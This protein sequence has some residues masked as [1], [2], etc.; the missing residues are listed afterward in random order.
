VSGFKLAPS[1]FAVARSSFAVAMGTPAG[2]NMKPQFDGTFKEAGA[3]LETYVL[4]H[5]NGS[6]ALVDTKTATCVSWKTADGKEMITKKDTVHMLNGAPL[7]GEFVPEERAKKVS[8]DRMIFKC[9]PESNKELEYRCDVTM[10]E[11]SLEYDITIK[12]SGAGAHDIEN[13]LK[14]NIDPSMKVRLLPHTV[15]A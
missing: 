7:T 15:F 6:K 4:E 11:D 5:E 14:F 8:F 12:N 2:V 9:T 1:K 3:H 13:S 10:R